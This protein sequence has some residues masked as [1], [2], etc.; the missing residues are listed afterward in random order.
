MNIEDIKQQLET[1]DR[2]FPEAA[3]RA[4][5]EQREAITPVLLDCLRSAAD[6]PRKVADTQGAMLH[7]YALYL[8]AQFR[9]RA[10]YPLVVKLFS[11][12]GDLCLDLAEDFVTEDLYRVLASVCGGDL[13]PIK[14]MIE[15][16]EVNE[17]VRSACMRTLVALVEWGELEREPV[18][19]YFRS[20]FNGKLE[21]DSD[22]LWGALVSACCDLYP[23]ELLPEIERAFAD[24]LVDTFFIQMD[25]VE[26]AMA[27]DKDQ[28]TRSAKEKGPIEDTVSEMNWWAYIRDTPKVAK[29]APTFVPHT[30]IQSVKVGRNDPCPCGSGKKYKKC[31]LQ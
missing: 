11:A 8:L 26:R 25:S 22:F 3:V 27:E 28:A 15:D 12:P 10:A 6:D 7:M 16:R 1:M 21:R 5:V 29:P 31:C 20:L 18:I 24:G 9:E 23:E 17:Y 19:E 30:P 2:T 14:G 4:A 13:D